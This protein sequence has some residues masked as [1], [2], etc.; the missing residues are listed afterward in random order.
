MMTNLG[1]NASLT[2]DIPRPI[3]QMITFLTSHICSTNDAL[4]A[5]F[6]QI[7]TVST[8]WLIGAMFCNTAWNRIDE[9]LSWFATARPTIT[10]I[11][12]HF[13]ADPEA[14][15]YCLTCVYDI[16]KGP[17]AVILRFSAN[18]PKC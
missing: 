12:P 11:S 5:F 8:P 6:S 4:T 1:Q 9:A 18:R 10:W 2:L 3:S 16:L 15:T 13:D 17:N 7:H 14:V